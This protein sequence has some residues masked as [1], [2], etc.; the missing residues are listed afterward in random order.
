MTWPD[1]VAIGLCLVMGVVESKRGFVPA[2]CA[3]IGVLL[4]VEIAG[5]TYQ[6]LVSPSLSYASA[7]VVAVLI[8]L[9]VV[10][11]VTV[12]IQRYAP[13]DIGSFD[14]S[15]GGL[16]GIFT[17]LLMSHAMYGAV[18]LAAGGETAPVFAHSALGR[19]IYD[20]D[21]V[22]AFLDFMHHLG[23][24]DVTDPYARAKGH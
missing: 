19:Q 9:V 1:F 16:I 2:F 5:S 15:M 22:H 7:Y 12:L 13:T 10:G 18:I 6:H 14:S 17:G 23:G 4:T 24:S 20:L 21:G 3:M 11:I 8:G